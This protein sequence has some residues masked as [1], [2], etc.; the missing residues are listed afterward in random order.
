MTKIKKK[1]TV[2]IILIAVFIINIITGFIIM[3]EILGSRFIL[4]EGVNTNQSQLA[5]FTVKNPSMILHIISG[6]LFLSLLVYHLLLNWRTFTGYF[7]VSLR[8]K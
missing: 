8:K 4:N 2:D 7:R 1:F 6:I 3:F 5:S